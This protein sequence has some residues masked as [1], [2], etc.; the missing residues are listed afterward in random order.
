MKS[1]YRTLASSALQLL[2]AAAAPNNS[3][4]REERAAA[5]AAGLA[6]GWE[7]QQDDDPRPGGEGK[8]GPRAFL[9]GR[10]ATAAAAAPHKLPPRMTSCKHKW[11]K[12]GRHMLA[13][14][15]QARDRLW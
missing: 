5:V 8:A 15:V 2:L 11:E 7:T 3:G 14:T 9:R 1:S 12:N 6:P 4:A 10:L 13:T